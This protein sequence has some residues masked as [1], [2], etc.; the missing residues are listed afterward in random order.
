MLNRY[1][2]YDKR[3]YDTPIG[4]VPSTTTV[5]KVL[6]KPALI[7]WAA[8]MTAEYMRGVLMSVAEGRIFGDDLT[9]SE[10]DRLVK[11]AKSAHKRESTGAADIGSAVHAWIEGYYKSY[12]G[13][14]GL[15]DVPGDEM[16]PPIEAFRDWDANNKVRPICVEERIWSSE[17]FAGTL[18]LYAEVKGVPTIVDFKSSSGHWDDHV[19]QLGAYDMAFRERTGNRVDGY[20][21]VRL[22][23]KTGLPDPKSYS[24]E[25]VELGAKRF[26]A[27]LKYFWLTEKLTEK[28][29]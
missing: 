24:R 21:I 9:D 20:M 29:K 6:S 17:R 8:K 25:E 27:L 10:I 13:G 14:P 4:R 12:L 1:E 16:Y 23:K 5:L 28:G 15:Q 19:M 7:G 3:Y 2:E 18:D 22:D 11:E 26:L